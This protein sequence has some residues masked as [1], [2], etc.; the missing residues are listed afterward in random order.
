LVTTSRMSFFN[1]LKNFKF[2]TPEKKKINGKPNVEDKYEMN[3]LLGT[4]AFSEVR[5]A[6]KKEDGEN[7]AI[8]VIR[9]KNLKD[10]VK[11][12]E[13]EI[14]VLNRLDHEN[15]VKLVET[16]E[17]PKCV[18][19]VMELV[20]GGELF[21]RIVEKGSYSE[22]DAADVVR[23]V[24]EATAYMH[25]QGVVHRDLK[26]ENLLY[27]SSS[28]DSRIVVTDFGL[29]KLVES[30]PL[31]TSCGTPG[32][33]APEVLS[34]KS[35]GAEVDAWSIGII[36]YIL[37]CGYPPFYDENIQKLLI[38]IVKGEVMFDPPFWDEISAEAKHF[39][40]SLI[41][42]NVEDR[43]SCH[44]ALQHPWIIGQQSNRN[45]HR[46]ISEQ[47]RNNAAKLRWKQPYNTIA[48]IREMKML[49]QQRREG[50]EER[51][52]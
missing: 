9:K 48:A 39:V 11:G 51:E 50:N 7:F 47:L 26:P 6:K 1:N 2:K 38:Q 8:K 25:E 40:R 18:Y 23:Q 31:V 34:R 46:S 35:Y 15:I 24:L 27:Y 42:V 4:G 30:G 5:R 33:L 37:L 22:K 12:I 44:S 3:E 45:F 10:S 13:N 41:C 19:L 49:V 36:T 32:Y 17:S 29:S 43:L 14:K 52:R 20:T 28:E 21:D 16:F